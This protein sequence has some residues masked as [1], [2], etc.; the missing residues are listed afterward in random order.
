MC[1][2]SF[3]VERDN[4]EFVGRQ[5]FPTT[6]TSGCFSLDDVLPGGFHI[7]DRI[8][9]G[10]PKINRTRSSHPRVNSPNLGFPE[11]TDIESGLLQIN[12]SG[13]GI[14]EIN[15]QKFLK[16]NGLAQ[17][18]LRPVGTACF[19]N[20]DLCV[21][22]TPSNWTTGM[23]LDDPESQGNDSAPGLDVQISL[24]FAVVSLLALVAALVLSSE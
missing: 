14:L 13:S 21:P 2:L 15:L 16:K 9:S 17:S 12:F 19:C 22:E 5:C 8:R 18:Q 4:R 7:A 23:K 11:I 20:S 6:K 1:I 3:S 24:T 10:F